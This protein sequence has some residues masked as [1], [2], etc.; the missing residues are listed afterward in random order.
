M[1]TTI[2]HSEVAREA[3]RRGADRF[4]TDR[5][6]DMAWHGA[7]VAGHR[8]G[9]HRALRYT[10]MRVAK[11]WPLRGNITLYRE[12]GATVRLGHGKRAGFTVKVEK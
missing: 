11:A 9:D 7:I 8:N 10:G 4:F 3:V 5:I 1:T 6:A 12:D 2:H